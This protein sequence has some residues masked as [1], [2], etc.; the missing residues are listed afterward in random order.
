M[1]FKKDKLLFEVYHDHLDHEELI[2]EILHKI[3]IEKRKPA[4]KIKKLLLIKQNKEINRRFWE[5]L[6]AVMPGHCYN[7]VGCCAECGALELREQLPES[8][9]QS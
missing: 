3:A 6:D 1:F 5:I 8:T 2:V 9:E 7:Y 4:K